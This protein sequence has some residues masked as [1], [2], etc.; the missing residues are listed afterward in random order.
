MSGTVSAAREASLLGKPAIAISQFFRSDID[1]DW[2]YS[3]RMARATIAELIRRDLPSRCFWVVNLP[4]VKAAE[5]IPRRT[6]CEADRNP[7]SLSYTRDENHF[8]FTSAYFDRPRT[9]GSDV[10]VCFSG[11]ISVT[12][13]GP[14]M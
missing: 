4:A 12:L 6:D 2:E 14:Q 8:R 3:A 1:I 7:Y 11:S 10:D 5:E 9:I 13:E